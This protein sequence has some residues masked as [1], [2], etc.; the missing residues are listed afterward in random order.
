MYIINVFLYRHSLMIGTK[1]GHLYRHSPTS[2]EVAASWRVLHGAVGGGVINAP[3]YRVFG[4]HTNDR[5]RLH[6][7]IYVMAANGDAVWGWSI[8]HAR[9]NTGTRGC[10]RKLTQTVERDNN[11][12]KKSENGTVSQL[13]LASTYS[14]IDLQKF[15]CMGGHCLGFVYNSKLT[16]RSVSGPE[17]DPRVSTT[18]DPA[19]TMP[20]DL[21]RRAVWD[22]LSSVVYV[23]GSG[24]AD[25]IR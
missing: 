15:P 20:A 18:P 7:A 16:A 8:H 24:H 6:S 17:L 14:L 19:P 11:W 2:P 3:E 21:V 4:T 23:R 13:I 1:K 10:D 25:G 9:M 12:W 22:L 5:D